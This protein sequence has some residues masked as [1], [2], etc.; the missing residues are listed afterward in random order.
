[1]SAT[2]RPASWTGLNRPCWIG[3]GDVVRQLAAA[4]RDASVIEAMRSTQAQGQR[5]A[6]VRGAPS[7]PSNGGVELSL[8]EARVHRYLPIWVGLSEATRRGPAGP[9]ATHLTVR[10]VQCQRQ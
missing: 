8:H 5:V 4:G 7:R 9:A 6:G 2:P 1:M 3:F 10:E